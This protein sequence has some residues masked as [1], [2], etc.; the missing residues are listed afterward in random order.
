MF[1]REIGALIDERGFIWDIIVGD[2]TNL[3]YPDQ[4][5]WGMSKFAQKI[6]L[7]HTHPPY[8]SNMSGEDRSTLLAWSY[9]LPNRVEMQIICKVNNRIVVRRNRFVIEPL[10]SWIKR[11][12][13]RERKIKL[14]TQQCFRIWKKPW[15][16]RLVELSYL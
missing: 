11:G 5:I 3:L 8:I 10:E 6:I 14:K 15:V 7:A 4:K 1:R 9:A 12:K 2:S 16:D 13:K